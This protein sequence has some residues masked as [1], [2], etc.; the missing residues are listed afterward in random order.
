MLQEH[1][2]VGQRIEEFVVEVWTSQGWQVICQGGTVGYK[3]LLRCD[4]LTTARVRLRILGSRFAPT[5]SHFGLYNM[6]A[7]GG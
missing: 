4:R 2:A 1:I 6:P 3:R 5:L 7:N